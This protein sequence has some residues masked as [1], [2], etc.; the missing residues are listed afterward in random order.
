MSAYGMDSDGL[1]ARQSGQGGKVEMRSLFKCNAVLALILASVLLTGCGGKDVQGGNEGESQRNENAT[2]QNREDASLNVDDSSNEDGL[3]GGQN[4]DDD[5]ENYPVIKTADYSDVAL[6]TA[7]NGQIRC[8]YPADEWIAW[9]SDPIQIFCLETL[10]SD[11]AVNITMSLASTVKAPDNYDW[12]EDMLSQ[13]E[14]GA[15][16]GFAIT[17]ESIEPRLLNGETV[18]YAEMVTEITDEMIDLLVEQGI[19]TEEDIESVGGREVLLAVPPTTQI[20]I[21]A[22]Q[23][24]YLYTCTGTYYDQAQKQMVLDTMAIVIGTVERQ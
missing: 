14:G 3:A 18:V 24:G 23:G 8:S 10:E 13:L 16:D 22:K 9:E 15:L 20:S 17:I 11:Q 1:S 7:E 6:E 21:T 5:A 2:G 4:S 12:I 19:Y